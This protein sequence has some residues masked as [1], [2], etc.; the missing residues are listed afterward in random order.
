MAKLKESLTVKIMW[1]FVVVLKIA[2][3]GLPKQPRDP[4]S[5]F[6]Y[7]HIKNGFSEAAIC[8]L[9]EIHG[10]QLRFSIKKQ[11]R[12]ANLSGLSVVKIGEKELNIHYPK[13]LGCY[14]VCS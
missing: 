1:R 10:H 9:R 3:V 5:S 11:I 8:I 6:S 2:I 4:G 12:A 14:T 7:N 13:I